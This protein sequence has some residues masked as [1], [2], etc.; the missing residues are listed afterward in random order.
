[1]KPSHTALICLALLA[2]ACKEKATP[3][4]RSAPQESNKEVPPQEPNKEVTLKPTIAVPDTFK[5]ALGK[6]FDGYIRIQSALALDDLPKAKE[7]FSSMHAKLH[8]IPKKGLDSAAKA[9]WDSTDARFMAAL[10]P[11]GSA[12]TLE[13]FRENFPDFTIV[14]TEAIEKFGIAGNESIYQFHCPMAENGQGAD[15]LQKDSVMAN[16]YYGSSML[17]CGELV[18]ILRS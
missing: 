18:R 1:M 8:V 9:E 3:E 10:H 17:K 16:P 2:S 11:M 14:L 15:W 13:A 12:E 4:T 6:V 5:V 7:E